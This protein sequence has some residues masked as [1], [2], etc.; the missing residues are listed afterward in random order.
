M[1]YEIL[2]AIIVARPF[3]RAI[4]LCFHQKLAGQAFDVPAILSGLVYHH[5]LY[6][7][8]NNAGRHVIWGFGW[9]VKLMDLRKTTVPVAGQEV[10]TTDNVGLKPSLLV[11]CQVADPAKAM[12]ER[13]LAGRPL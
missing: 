8:R 3:S 7:R 9:T 11:T 5:G 12:H 4:A 6:V 1:N 10:L 13:K 2:L